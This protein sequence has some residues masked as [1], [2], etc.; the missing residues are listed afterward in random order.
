LLETLERVED[1]ILEALADE[2]VRLCENLK[3]KFLESENFLEAEKVEAESASKFD[4]NF[5]Q[6]SAPKI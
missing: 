2:K 6:E 5:V 1:R 3:F 4:E